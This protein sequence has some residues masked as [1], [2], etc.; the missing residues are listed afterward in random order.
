ML[1]ESV[2]YYEWRSAPIELD[3]D[4]EMA[5]LIVENLKVEAMEA[6][7][8]G[9][10]SK[11]GDM[12]RSIDVLTTKIDKLAEVKAEKEQETNGWVY[13]ADRVPKHDNDVLVSV[14]DD[15]DPEKT[16]ISIDSYDTSEWR[17]YS[18]NV[19][20]WRELPEPAEPAEDTDA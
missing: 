3:V 19:I 2:S 6:V 5:R 16:F 20:A 9:N 8:D 17:N 7:S 10:F 13:C 11:A 18:T 4:E 12:I 15:N 14:K 1:I